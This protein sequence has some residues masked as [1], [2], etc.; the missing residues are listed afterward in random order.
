MSHALTSFLLILTMLFGCVSSPRDNRVHYPITSGFHT[1]LP[2]AETRVI[3][4]GH[5]RAVVDMAETW[6]RSHGLTVIEQ[7]RLQP[8]LEHNAAI[9]VR[10]DLAPVLRAARSLEARILVLG[11]SDV[12][13]D[14]VTQAGIARVLPSLDVTVRGVNVA[15]G[16]IEWKGNAHSPSGA[17][18]RADGAAELTCQALAKRLGVSPVR[19]ARDPV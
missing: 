11:D 5:D 12:S 9:D 1:T 13:L 19:T 6:L 2:P 17:H 16:R 14:S 3:V 8:A 4:Y 10:N 15:T 7:E 18:V